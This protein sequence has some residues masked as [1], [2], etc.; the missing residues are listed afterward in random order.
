MKAPFQQANFLFHRNSQFNQGLLGSSQMTPI[1]GPQNWAKGLLVTGFN[2]A[3]HHQ[4]LPT[5]SG[6][7]PNQSAFSPYDPAA[8]DV[9][10]LPPSNSKNLSGLSGGLFDFGHQMPGQSHLM[11]GSML[12][13]MG[14]Q[15]DMYSKLKPQEMQY[16]SFS[17]LI[18]GGRDIMGGKLHRKDSFDH[19]HHHDQD[20]D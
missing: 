5:L 19:G 18:G 12:A 8:K 17:N 7:Q 15:G 1:G 16:S 9:G 4:K 10:Y 11:Q 20:Q 6:F 14:Y 2:P 3:H 13:D